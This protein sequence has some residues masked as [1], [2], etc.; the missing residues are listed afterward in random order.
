MRSNAVDQNEM[1]RAVLT[2][3]MVDTRDGSVIA[4]PWTNYVG[5]YKTKGVAKGVITQEIHR[6]D[7]QNKYD[8]VHRHRRTEYKAHVE[9]AEMTWVE[10]AP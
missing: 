6:W 9:K 2:H 8:E 3:W 10:V 7:N 1:F 5:P 4:G